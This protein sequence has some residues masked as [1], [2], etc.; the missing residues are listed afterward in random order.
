MR[1]INSLKWKIRAVL[2]RKI[3]PAQKIKY[4]LHIN[5]INKAYKILLELHHF[6]PVYSNLLNEK[7]L[8]ATFRENNKEKFTIYSQYFQNLLDK[9]PQNEILYEAFLRFCIFFND[10][11]TT[12]KILQK[13]IEYNIKSQFVLFNAIRIYFDD[14]KL[15]KLNIIF[16]TLLETLPNDKDVLFLYNAILN[17][18]CDNNLYYNKII[19]TILNKIG[20]QK[21]EELHIHRKKK[22]AIY[23]LNYYA[24]YCKNDLLHMNFYLPIIKELPPDQFD[25]ITDELYQSSDIKNIYGLENY[26]IIYDPKIINQYDYV[27]SDC[28]VAIHNNI[29]NEHQKFIIYRH[30]VNCRFNEKILDQCSL[31]ITQ[32]DGCI[33]NRDYLIY[34]PKNDDEFLKKLKNIKKCELAYAGPWHLCDIY[35]SQKN[36]NTIYKKQLSKSLGVNIPLDKPVVCFLEGAY[37]E[38][39]DLI[40][41]ELIKGINKLS[42]HFFIIYKWRSIS[43][44]NFKEKVSSNVVLYNSQAYAPNL[45]KL[46]SDFIFAEIYSGTF[47]SSVMLGLNIIPYYTPHLKTYLD[48][49]DLNNS[50]QNEYCDSLAIQKKL[51]H[52]FKY[53]FNILDTD[54]I[55]EAISSKQYSIW[56]NNN[57]KNLQEVFGN[58]HTKLSAKIAAEHIIQ[59]IQDGTLE[60]NATAFYLK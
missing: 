47:L 52:K 33:F 1:F 26:N 25:I 36:D 44:F 18:N 42:E 9:Y 58:Y 45:L 29:F 46:A 35:N 59:F 13:A 20:I 10:T 27:L 51:L 40:K 49:K 14:K 7:I 37:S 16:S 53:I 55:V 8:P 30:D 3:F 31:F 19:S 21:I 12:H 23:A 24:E 48:A 22:L 50:I 56:Y 39:N 32:Y 17:N 28:A 6:S 34:P 60:K 15:D 4:S 43:N 2:P 41:D 57:L 54:S 38:K 11:S 5:D